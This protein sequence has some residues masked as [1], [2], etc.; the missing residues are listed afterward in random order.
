MSDFFKTSDGE[1]TA[2]GGGSFDGGGGDFTPIPKG[3]QVLAAIDEIAWDELGEFS[4]AQGEDF[5]KA[6]WTVL[7]PEEFKN[8]KINHKIRPL[9]EDPK[10]ADKAKKMF[11]AIDA[12][13]GGKLAKLGKLP[14][15]IALQGL[16]NKPMVLMLQVWSMDRDGEKMEGNWVSSVSPKKGGMK[17]AAPKAAEPE[18]EPASADVGDGGTLDDD[19]PF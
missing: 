14:D 16:T 13:A 15:D 12:N 2:A 8:R 18:A 5:I 10:K 17:K 11:A 9:C 4:D 6:R 7:Q 3:T 19:I 1:D